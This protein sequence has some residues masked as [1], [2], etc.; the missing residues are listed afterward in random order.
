MSS[1]P[2]AVRRA[3]LW[4][5]G[6][7]ANAHISAT[8][9]IDFT[10]SKAYLSSLSEQGFKISVHHLLVA[11]ITRTLVEF[12]MANA[13]IFG[14][15]IVSIQDVGVGMPVNLLGHPGERKAELTMAVLAQ[16]NQLTLAELAAKQR[17]TIQEERKGK[18][19]NTMVKLLFGLA[20]SAPDLV[21]YRGMDLMSRALQSPL[22]GQR[23]FQYAPVTTGI[24]NPGAVV[25]DPGLLFRAASVSI[26]QRLVHVG[27]LWGIGVIQDEVVAIQG[28][29]EIR[30]ML[31]VALM[32]DHRLFDGVMAGRLLSFFAGVLRDPARYFGLAADRI[33]GGM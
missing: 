29:M 5:F 23:M 17:Q 9:A 32:F 16:T 15:K 3:L 10:Q 24:T 14:R 13:R 30:P 4:W 12:P 1:P 26:P 21:F 19:Q 6:H 8:V 33:I 27:T 11:A 18:A 20:E 28:K 25:S 2:S 22:I 7:P 31:P